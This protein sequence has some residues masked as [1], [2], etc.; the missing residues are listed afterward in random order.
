[1]KKGSVSNSDR[2]NGGRLWACTFNELIMSIRASQEPGRIGCKN[3]VFH[4][5]TILLRGVLISLAVPSLL[6]AALLG[7]QFYIYYTE[8]QGQQSNHQYHDT[9]FM[10]P[11][12]DLA[13]FVKICLLT[14]VGY[15]VILLTLRLI[16]K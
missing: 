3:E 5:L 10:I 2:L 7:F 11:G 15:F 4:L 8:H 12:L 14:W 1:M 9:L 13:L 16:K 6:Y